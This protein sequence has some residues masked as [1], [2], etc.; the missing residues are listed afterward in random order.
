MMSINDAVH[1][2]ELELETWLGDR[3][4]LDPYLVALVSGAAFLL[5]GV[6]VPT[7]KWVLLLTACLCFALSAAGV[8]SRVNLT[9]AGLA[10]WVLTRLF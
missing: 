9:A 6:F 5:M 4:A 10:C 7:L 2:A 8:T 3:P 1:A